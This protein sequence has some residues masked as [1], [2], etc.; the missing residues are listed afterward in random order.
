MPASKKRAQRRVRLGK[1]LTAMAA[2]GTQL[3]LALRRLRCTRSSA[4]SG[5]RARPP[6]GSRCGR[7][8]SVKA[9][10]ADPRSGVGCVKPALT[11]SC[12]VCVSVPGVRRY[13]VRVR[14]QTHAVCASH[15]A[16]DAEQ[17][18]Q[19]ANVKCLLQ[20]ISAWPR[21]GDG[22]L[23]KPRPLRGPCLHP[24]FHLHGDAIP[25]ARAKCLHLLCC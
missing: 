20:R 21:H 7:N 22:E 13:S 1:V 17:R 9:H 10:V 12:S 16:G 5:R 2:G 4:A 24:G 15:C 18:A 14:Q 3:G 6:C 23:R 25:G 8:R 19:S 11:V